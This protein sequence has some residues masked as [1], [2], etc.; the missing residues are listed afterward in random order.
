M[1]KATRKISGP[2]MERFFRHYFAQEP[3]L[4]PPVAEALARR[5]VATFSSVQV[6]K[7]IALGGRSVVRRVAA[8]PVPQSAAPEMPVAELQAP[9]VAFDPYAFGLVPTLQREGRAGLLAKLGTVAGV[10][11]LRQMARAQ[12]ISLAAELRTG[13][14][15]SDALRSA[16]ADA[17]EKRIA[18]R[19]AAAGDKG[20]N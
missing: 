9:G 2:Q 15:D 13:T 4:E 14:V 11:Q 5:S 17:V 10:D 18:D 7:E 6:R 8:R 20:P 19:R 1:R 16:I 3:G 12:Q